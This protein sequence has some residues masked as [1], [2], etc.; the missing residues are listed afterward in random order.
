MAERERLVNPPYGMQPFHYRSTIPIC[1]ALLAS[2]D[3]SSW[4]R[5]FELV[6]QVVCR[7]AG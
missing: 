7:G 6:K 3:T 4:K 5:F 1:H 2:K